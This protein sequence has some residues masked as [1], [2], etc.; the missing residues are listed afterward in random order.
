[1]K[2]SVA[3]ETLR[4]W[5]EQSEVRTCK[6]AGVPSDAQDEVRKLK[7]DNAEVCRANETLKGDPGFKSSRHHRVLRLGLGLGGLNISEVGYRGHGRSD[8]DCPGSM[9]SVWFSWVD[10]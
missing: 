6:K 1:M 7:R 10:Q 2:L 3:I 8:P 5:V 9:R 4:R